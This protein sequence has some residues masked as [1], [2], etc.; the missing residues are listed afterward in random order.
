MYTGKHINS[1]LSTVFLIIIVICSIIILGA[2]M[3]D[4]WK[5]IRDIRRRGDV[6]QVIKVVEFYK[7]R[8]NSLPDNETE[9]DW[10]SSYDPDNNNQ[11]LFKTLREKKLLSHIFD[12]KNNEEYHYRYHKFESGEYGCN[13][14]FAIFQVTS[15]E[16]DV[17]NHGKCECPERNFIDEAPNGFTYQWFE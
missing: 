4:R 13:R 10:D 12:P 16:E 5:K 6:Q 1:V 11:T 3:N 8:Y 14:T 7:L 2:Y 17:Y 15:F 9:N